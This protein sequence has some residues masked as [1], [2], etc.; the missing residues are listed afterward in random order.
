MPGAHKPRRAAEVLHLALIL[1][2]LRQTLPA[3][4]LV[5]NKICVGGFGPFLG[6]PSYV[7]MAVHRMGGNDSGAPMLH[8]VKS[9]GHWEGPH[10]LRAL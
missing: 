2:L 10:R 4:L 1:T 3:T 8:T 9:L 7:G 5:K 6:H